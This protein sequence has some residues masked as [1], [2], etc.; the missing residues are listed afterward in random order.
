LTVICIQ[1][2]LAAVVD[3]NLAYFSGVDGEEQRA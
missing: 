2:Y 3:D 1:V